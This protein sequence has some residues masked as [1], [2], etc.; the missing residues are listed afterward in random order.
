MVRELELSRT[1][2]AASRAAADRER[3]SKAWGACVGTGWC[4]DRTHSGGT[5]SLVFECTTQRWLCITQWRADCMSWRPQRRGGDHG[6]QGSARPRSGHD[7]RGLRGPLMMNGLASEMPA[8][9]DVAGVT[10]RFVTLPG[11]AGPVRLHVISRHPR[12]RARGRSVGSEGDGRGARILANRSGISEGAG[13]RGRGRRIEVDHVG[14]ARRGE[15]EEDQRP[16]RPEPFLAA[17]AN[18]PCG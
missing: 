5:H 3:S 14:G 12:V 15:K 8:F 11:V 9:R 17:S 10:H 4:S 6:A 13:V 2:G 16:H 18:G 1:P 7:R